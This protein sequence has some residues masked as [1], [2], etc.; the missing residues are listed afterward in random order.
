MKENQPRH[1]LAL[2]WRKLVILLQNVLRRRLGLEVH[3]Y[4]PEPPGSNVLALAISDIVL[5]R[6]RAGGSPS[7]LTF[8]QI[9]ANDGITGDP[10]H[11]FVTRYGFRGVC[12]E[13]QPDAFAR[14]QATYRDQPGVACVHAAIAA[15]DGEAT[16]Y[17]FR[18]GPGVPEWADGLAT[19]SRDLLVTNFQGL[20][21]EIEAVTVPT[22]TIA[23][24]L[25]SQ[26]VETLDLVQIDTEGFDFA[27][28]QLLLPHIRPTVIHF[29]AGILMPS[30]RHA[31]YTYLARHGYTVTPNGLD[32]MAYLEPPDQARIPIVAQQ[33]A[34]TAP[35]L[36]RATASS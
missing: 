23:S 1:R 10:I 34:F 19:F 21:G 31:C 22:R 28:I 17:R 11:T 12:V 8:L 16:L 13:P 26:H 4:W 20:Q 7:D 15:N 5:R 30:E 27:I 3:R 2:Q 32:A 36:A 18:P 29:E 35:A 25:A 9:G 33:E 24:L 6:I 14:L